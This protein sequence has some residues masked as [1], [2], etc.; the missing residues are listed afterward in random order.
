[1]GGG[2]EIEA[3]G[4]GGADIAVARCRLWRDLVT[5]GLGM[6][7]GPDV[8]SETDLKRKRYNQ[9]ICRESF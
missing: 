3:E 2:R 9:R 7:G 1:M 8:D 5:E 6:D 4:E